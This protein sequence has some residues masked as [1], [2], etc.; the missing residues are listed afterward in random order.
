MEYGM[1]RRYPT[2]LIGEEDG[3]GGYLLITWGKHDG[4]ID[5]QRLGESFGDPYEKAVALP[6]SRVLHLA[7]GTTFSVPEASIHGHERRHRSVVRRRP[8]IA[9]GS[10]VP[11]V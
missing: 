2:T 1:R 6:E 8:P 11:T 3:F 4:V 10:V 5:T 9:D 7:P